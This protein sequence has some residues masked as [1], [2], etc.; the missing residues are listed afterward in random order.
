MELADAG[1]LD[2]GKVG[3][4]VHA[5]KVGRVPEKVQLVSNHRKA[6]GLLV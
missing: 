4:T 3:A 2:V 5:C 6:G 1:R